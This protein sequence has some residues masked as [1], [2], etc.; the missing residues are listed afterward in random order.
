MH[1]F[2]FP[3]FSSFIFCKVL[4]GLH[5]FLLPLRSPTCSASIINSIHFQ[6]HYQTR[7]PMA[8]LV[9]IYSPPPLWP[10]PTVVSPRDVNAGRRSIKRGVF[11][12]YERQFIRGGSI[13]AST[14]NPTVALRNFWPVCKAFIVSLCRHNSGRYVTG[15]GWFICWPWRQP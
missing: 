14:I 5:A 2:L 13:P 7:F 15:N 3:I 12:I 6:P 9:Q 4:F 11:L 10:R 1:R 8:P